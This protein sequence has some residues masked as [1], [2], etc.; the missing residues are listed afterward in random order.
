MLTVVKRYD[1]KLHLTE[2]CTAVGHT[3]L[4][5]QTYLHPESL[6]H[7]TSAHL[8]CVQL[9]KLRACVYTVRMHVHVLTY[10]VVR[11]YNVHMPITARSIS[12]QP[13]LTNSC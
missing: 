10:T 1:R 6:Y 13:Q 7:N 11:I 9:F 5:V 8:H 4:H 2:T 12:L 3:F